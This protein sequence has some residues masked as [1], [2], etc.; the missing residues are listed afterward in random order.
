VYTPFNCFGSRGGRQRGDAFVRSFAH[1]AGKAGREGWFVRG[2]RPDR[3]GGPWSSFF[4]AFLFLLVFP[5]FPV[6]GELLFTGQVTIPSLM[7]LT[8][9]YA[10]SLS[11]SSTHIGRW[12]MGIMVGFVFSTLFGWSMGIGDAAIGPAYRIGYGAIAGD[13]WLWTAGVGIGMVFVA[14][15]WERVVRHVIDAEVFPEFLRRTNAKC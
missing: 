9:T 15:V 10:V 7:L 1:G 5:L 11:I 6:G 14:H 2:Y 12:A 8:A 4:V 3:S 13:G